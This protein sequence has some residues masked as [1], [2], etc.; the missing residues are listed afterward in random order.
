MNV[1]TLREFERRQLRGVDPALFEHAKKRLG[2]FVYVSYELGGVE[3]G[4]KHHVGYIPIH[5]ELM[6]EVVPKFIGGEW[7]FFYLLERAGASP[8]VFTDDRTT[9]TRERGMAERPAEF[10]VRE[11]LRQLVVLRRDGIYRKS[12]ERVEARGGV[13]GKINLTD[14]IRLFHSRCLPHRLQCS[15]FDATADIPENRAIKLA[16]QRII[17]TPGIPGDARRELRNYHR[18][19]QALTPRPREDVCALVRRSLQR[20]DIPDTRHYYRNLLG[21]CLFILESS[22]IAFREGE[23]VTLCAFTMN[24]DD[25]FERFVLA[26]AQAGLASLGFEVF[27]ADKS[28][29]KKQLFLNVEEPLITPDVVV[30][31]GKTRFV[32]DAKYINRL[33]NADEFYQILAYTMAYDCKIGALALPHVGPC[34]PIEYRTAS[35]LIIVYFVDLNDPVKAEAD[36]G[37]WLRS[38]LSQHVTGAA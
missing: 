10:I 21:L 14:T 15:F 18:L 24:M 31:R 1:L 34:A 20:L 9:M 8:K 3:I 17:D 22:T 32:F 5:S 26:S 25:I 29:N 30:R 27:K 7:D 4:A 33:P 2:E 11:F 12:V 38:L 35:Q 19:F 23:E 28:V 36:I 16:I 13:K 6:L 37:T